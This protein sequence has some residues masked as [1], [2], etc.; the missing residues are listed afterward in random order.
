[1]VDERLSAEFD[2]RKVGR[3]AYRRWCLAFWAMSAMAIGGLVWTL[4]HPERHPFVFAASA[5]WFLAVLAGMLTRTTLLSVDPKR[6]ALSRWEHDGRIYDRLGLDVF[7]WLLQHTPLGW[8]EPFLTVRAGRGDMGRLL[9]E[10][11]FA[12]GSHL[13]QGVAS[14]GLAVGFLA[15]GKA[16]V[17]I[18]FVAL[19]VPLHI[20]PIMLQRRNRGRVFRVT[21][22]VEGRRPTRG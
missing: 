20:Y 4:W 3:E 7:A 14:L 8:L 21:A 2:I 19:G 17:A 15:I 6:F 9:R 1:M 11:D 10:L 5:T 18:A 22:R 13:V 12:E 16:A